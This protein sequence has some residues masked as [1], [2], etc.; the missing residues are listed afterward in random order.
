MFRYIEIFDASYSEMVR[1]CH[2]NRLRVPR[3]PPPGCVGYGYD[4]PFAQSGYSD[5]RAPAP[6]PL[7]FDNYTPSGS[8]PYYGSGAAAGGVQYGGRLGNRAD[9]HARPEPYVPPREEPY[10]LGAPAADPYARPRDDPFA[11]RAYDDAYG[12]PGYPPSGLS[13]PYA[14]PIESTWRDERPPPP[15]SGYAPPPPTM[16]S[17]G[18]GEYAQ[19]GSGGGPMKRE[20]A[21]PHWRASEH[22]RPADAPRG[23]ERPGQRYVLK[24]RGVP[25]R[26]VESD[27]YEV[28]W[29]FCWL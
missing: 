6:G 22:D 29:F 26:A 11:R 23:R 15:P 4:S 19:Q 13:D 7:P 3:P 20:A 8:D 16:D 25:F 1:F 9:P 27:V 10:G 18:Y 24:M 2:D 28:G 5:R 12:R 14:R 17:Y 21:A